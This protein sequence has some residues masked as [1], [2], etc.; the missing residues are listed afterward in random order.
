MIIYGPGW[1]SFFGC[2]S[3]K[4]LI[5][6]DNPNKKGADAK[7]I[8]QQPHEQASQRRT[9]KEEEGGSSK[10]SSSRSSSCRSG[11]HSGRGS[12]R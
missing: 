3:L 1:H 2:C 9:R 10:A 6:A 5:M 12:K 7:R 4:L 8:S 11:S